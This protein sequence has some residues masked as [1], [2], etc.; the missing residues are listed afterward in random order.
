MN[1]GFIS[2]GSGFQEAVSGLEAERSEAVGE[3]GEASKAESS[4]QSW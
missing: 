1:Q 4:R 3:R 2:P